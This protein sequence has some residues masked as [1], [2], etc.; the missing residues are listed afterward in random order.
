M[1]LRFRIHRDQRVVHTVVGELDSVAELR[2]YAEQL[3]G[4][5]EFEDGFD[6]LIEFSD[7]GAGVD[8]S[9]AVQV[10]SML[11][12]PVLHV[13]VA[14]VASGDLEFAVA[15]KFQSVYGLLD[16]LFAARRTLEEACAWL[17]IDPQPTGWGDW[18]IITGTTSETGQQEGG[19][20]GGT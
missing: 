18:R 17:R 15:C 19:A 16:D 2:T 9:G 11:V 12:P 6:H 14:I 20:G 3:K 10:L 4:A 8:G 13:R 1:S 7:G 5:P